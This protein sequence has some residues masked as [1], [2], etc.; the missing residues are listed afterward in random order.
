M[1]ISLLHSRAMIYALG[2]ARDVDVYQET[3]V[4][5]DFKCSNF[6]R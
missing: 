2:N 4:G 6:L 1:R 3:F 5:A